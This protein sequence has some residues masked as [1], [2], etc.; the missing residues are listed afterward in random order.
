MKTVYFLKRA[1]LLLVLA[2]CISTLQA[3]NTPITADKLPA[4]A[5]SF[6]N[7]YYPSIK[8]SYINQHDHSYH[9]GDKHFDYIDYK[10]TLENNAKIEFDKQGNW[11][12]VD[13]KNLPIPTG[14]IPAAIIKYVNEHYTGGNVTKIEKDTNKYEVEVNDDI[15]L[16]FD[17]NG[18]FLKID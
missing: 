15:D 5:L 13:G 8:I 9:N 12:E 2:F 17:L 3:E 7:T 10:V 1:A 11:K 16:K 6:L 18:K 14:F 4:A